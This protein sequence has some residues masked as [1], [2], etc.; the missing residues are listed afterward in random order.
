M[1][2]LKRQLKRARQRVRDRKEALVIPPMDDANREITMV[3]THLHTRFSD[4]V[5]GVKDVE[6]IC[7]WIGIGACITDHNEIRASLQLLERNRIP[8][9][10]ALEV[11]SRE[12]IELL[13]YFRNADDL[14]DF[15]RVHIEPYRKRR[16][17]AFLP[18]SLDNL[19]EG[20]REYDS[21]I[22]LPHPFAPLWKNIDHGRKR[23]PAVFR[24]LRDVDCIEIYNAALA[25]RANERAWRL[26]QRLDKIPLGGSDSHTLAGIGD[27]VVG[28]NRMVASDNL[29]DAMVNDDIYGVFSRRNR[30]YHISGAWQVAIRHSQKFV[31]PNG[32]DERA[33][34]ERAP[35]GVIQSWRRAAGL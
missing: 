33:L 23:H 4:G 2:K 32:A 7:R 14:I 21:L 29:F 15:Y 5:A 16:Y 22:S 6:D 19:V 34:Q 11:G 25:D 30:L 10:P 20:A 35:Q 27:V 17:Y 1:T 13:V 12:K 31:V 24:A 9:V 26:C 18:R 28:F 8:T 3:D